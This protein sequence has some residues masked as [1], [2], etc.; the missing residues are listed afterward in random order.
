MELLHKR[1]EA[2]AQAVWEGYSEK[3]VRLARKRLR[4]MCTGSA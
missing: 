4:G 3:M 2:A 1:D